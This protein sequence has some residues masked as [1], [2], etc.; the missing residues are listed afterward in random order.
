MTT[1]LSVCSLCSYCEAG[2][3]LSEVL[4]M[5]THSPRLAKALDA[6]LLRG[7]RINDQVGNQIG[8]SL[9]DSAIG[10]GISSGYSGSVQSCALWSGLPHQ[11]PG[12]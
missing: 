11:R 1:V 5:A 4:V 3:S 2:E 10:R 12:R 6:L 7:N 9:F 8:I